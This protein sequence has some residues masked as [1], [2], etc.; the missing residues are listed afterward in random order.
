MK[1]KCPKCRLT[2][3]AER[4]PGITELACNC[5]RCGTPFTFLVSEEELHKTQNSHTE[6]KSNEDN[7]I[8][9]HIVPP[10]PIESHEQPKVLKTANTQEIPT[11][12]HSKVPI[13]QT[14]KPQKRRSC[15][16]RIGMMLV[17][18]LMAA[19]IYGRCEKDPTKEYDPD[20][21][22]EN[23]D[24]AQTSK[25]IRNG[26]I[27]SEETVGNAPNWL[28]GT[29]MYE[30]KGDGGLGKIIIKIEGNHLTEQ[31]NED[32]PAGGSFYYKDEIL[33]FTSPVDHST[34]Q[35]PV[36]LINKTIAWQKNKWMTK[37]Q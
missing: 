13:Q 1:V 10:P 4:L 32:S 2:F 19:I 12:I 20:I 14:I 3:D 9:G 31:I 35:Y 16:E 33:H 21:V 5:P 15:L 7:P 25:N 24:S 26:E 23:R 22:I 37:V 6:E 18:L 8:P 30:D 28:D 29:W 11:Y 36:D 34:I 17:L 27:L